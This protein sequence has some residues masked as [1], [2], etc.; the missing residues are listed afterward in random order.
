MFGVRKS[1]LCGKASIYDV[2]IQ[3]SHGPKASAAGQVT[4]SVLMRGKLFHNIILCSAGVT[5]NGMTV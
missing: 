1:L 4:L 2:F 5:N 3:R